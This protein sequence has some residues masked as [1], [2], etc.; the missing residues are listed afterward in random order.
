MVPTLGLA[1]AAEVKLKEML[2]VGVIEPSE[3]PWSFRLVL[4]R[5]KDNSWRFCVDYQH[6]NYV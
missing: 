1:G 2:A 4:V 6:L 5:K 3:I